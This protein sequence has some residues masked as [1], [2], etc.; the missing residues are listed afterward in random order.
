MQF[1][2]TRPTSWSARCC[3]VEPQLAID[4][5]FH[6]R[7][8]GAATACI[9]LLLVGCSSS[10]PDKPENIDNSTTIGD[11]NGTPVNDGESGGNPEG[12]PNGE[13]GGNPDSEPDGESD[14]NPDGD[15]NGESGDNPSEPPPTSNVDLSGGDDDS[16]TATESLSLQGPFIKNPA[17]GAGPPSPPQGLTLL[18]SADNWMEFT[19]APSADDQ[20]VE[21]YEIF[22]DGTLIGTVRGDTGYEFDYRRWI[23]TSYIDCDYTHYPECRDTQPAVGSSH[24]YTVVAVDNEGMRSPHSPAAV[25]Q[26]QTPQ[27]GGVDL[28]GYSVV[29]NEEFDGVSLDRERWKT[30]MPWGPETTI[31]GEGQYFVNT[32]GSNPP[33]YDPFVFTGDTLQITAVETPAGLLDQANGKSYLS[34]VISTSDHFKMTYG[35]VEMKAKLVGGSGILS[36]FYLF[37]QDF[38]RNQPEIDIIEYIGDRPDKAYQTYHYYDSNRARYGSGEKHSSPTMET[39]VGVNL[40]S[41][42][43]RYGVLWEPE[44]VIWYIDDVEVRRMTGARVSDEPMNII[45]QLVIGSIWIGDP[46]PA[47]IPARLDID[48]IKAWQKP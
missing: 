16:P 30:S 25:F 44:L 39:N 6:R 27:S 48:Y 19:W 37:N 29:F 43:H 34:G 33:A 17:R 1:P 12:E 15:P 40:S 20:S 22:R 10:E 35:Y 14:G 36:T 9:L 47:A 3:S 5:S 38:E 45:A 32:F 24:A 7:I 28:A 11:Q 13:S 8:I 26:L 31:N 2:R 4:S 46:D 18:L 41:D 42:F 21:A 23:S